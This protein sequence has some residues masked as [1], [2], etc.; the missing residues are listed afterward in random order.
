MVRGPCKDD[1]D[2]FTNYDL[3]FEKTKVE[4]KSMRLAQA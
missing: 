4:D 3:V 2:W 1:L